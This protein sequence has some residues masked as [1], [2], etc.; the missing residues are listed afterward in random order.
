MNRCLCF[1]PLCSPWTTDSVLLECPDSCSTPVY[2]GKEH[3]PICSW[4]E[5]ERWTSAHRGTCGGGS[6]SSWVI[7]RGFGFWLRGLAT[8][9]LGL[10]LIKKAASP[11]SFFIR[12]PSPDL[13]SGVLLG[14]GCPA[15]KLPFS[16]GGSPYCVN[17]DGHHGPTASH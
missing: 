2:K 10:V 1:F 16:L 7:T 8:S 14:F 6:R 4:P 9:N 12:S 13:L 5:C 17:L 15:S 3:C 11:L